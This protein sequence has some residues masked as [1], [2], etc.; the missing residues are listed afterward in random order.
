MPSLLSK[1]GRALFDRPY[2][3]LSLTSLFWAGNIVLG[4]FVAGKVPPV[5][6]AW[7]RWAGCFALLN[8][9]T[10]RVTS[11]NRLLST[12]AYRLNGKTTY[13]LEGS[14]AVTGSTPSA[15]RMTFRSRLR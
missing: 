11:S 2:V 14:I 15:C 10:D 4:R 9:G 3:L 5:A 8:T 12:I 6:L 13:A 7:T 1:L